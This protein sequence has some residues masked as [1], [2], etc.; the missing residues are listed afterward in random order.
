[1]ASVGATPPNIVLILTDDQDVN[2]TKTMPSVQTELV[3]E[4]TTFLEAFA[5]LPMCS[6]AR[7][8]LLTGQY[9]HNHG[10]TDNEPP[11]GGYGKLDHTTTLPVW[12]Q[13]SGYYTGMIGRY[14]N[15]YGTTDTNTSDP[16][17]ADQEIPPGWNAWYGLIGNP[18]YY[19]YKI[20]ENGTVKSYGA[21][22]AD[23]LTDVLANQAD[24]F[25]RQSI[26]QP[27]FLSVAFKGPHDGGPNT[28]G[29][30]PAMRHAGKFS[31]FSPPRIANYNEADVADKPAYLKALPSFTGASSPDLQLL[32]QRRLESLLAVDEGVQKIVNALRDTGKLN[33]TVIIYASDN[34]W[35][36]GEHRVGGGKGLPHESSLQ[37]P[38]II[39]GPGI[40]K[41]RTVSELVVNVDLAPT[42]VELA[43]ATA[44]VT[45]TMDGQS[46]VPLL[47]WTPTS[48]R[49]AFLIESPPVFTSGK[50]TISDDKHFVDNVPIFQGVRTDQYVYVEYANAERELYDLKRD[51]YQLKNEEQNPV[52]AVVRSDL[53]A[54]LGTLMACAGANCW[55]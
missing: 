55:Q 46:L 12:L 2:S 40:A 18:G 38:L 36:T 22:S 11:D 7:A 43:G 21:S 39:R 35:F 50:Y 29:P 44:N 6:P 30:T 20:N 33:N 32:Y 9:A 3:Q 47:T 24:A 51:P 15:K 19:N 23:Y 16:I 1:M 48:W 8:T 31:Q 37:V 54:R 49:T 4:G 13:A 52:Y 28:I 14:L 25:L 41:E 17:P 45:R 42:I 5:S 34:G 10:V 26:P 27:F 53:Q